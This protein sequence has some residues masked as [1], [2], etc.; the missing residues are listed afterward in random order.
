ME[1]EDDNGG[2]KQV[3]AIGRQVDGSA[4]SITIIGMFEYL[5]IEF[6]DIAYQL[7]FLLQILI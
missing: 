6:G 2:Q 1:V 7:C 4:S 5:K 3:E